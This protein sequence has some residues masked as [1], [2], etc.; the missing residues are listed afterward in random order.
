MR[1]LFNESGQGVSTV[2]PGLAAEVIGWRELPSA[3][4]EILEVESEV[5]PP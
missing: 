5:L 2:G 3:G 1:G 4:D